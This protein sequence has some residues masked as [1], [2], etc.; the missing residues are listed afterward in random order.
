MHQASTSVQD[1]IAA[2]L[3]AILV[4]ANGTGFLHAA[5]REDIDVRML[6]TGRPFIYEAID[7]RRVLTCAKQ[8]E[9]ASTDSQV[10]KVKNYKL[11]DKS[12]FDSL[13]EIENSKAKR[14]L[15]VAH[16]KQGVT[17]ED[18]DKLNSLRN[19][20]LQ[21]Q[22]PLRVLHRR[23]QMN[24]DKMIY[25]MFAVKCGE[26]HILLHLLASA[27]TYIKE[28]VHGDL[29]R[30]VPNVASLLDHVNGAVDILQL[31]VMQVYDSIGDVEV[32]GDPHV[33]FSISQD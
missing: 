3:N 28:F 12:F 15:S 20:S 7:P 19:I 26:N 9:S 14:Y 29:G 16:F 18:C 10:V 33:I 27:G 23:S 30:T 8:L 21:Q 31:D 2:T 1:E 24:R 25:R 13:K 6:G 22:T 17:Q 4:P 11:V 5:G 32:E